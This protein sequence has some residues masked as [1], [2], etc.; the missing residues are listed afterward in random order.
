M[1]KFWIQFVIRE[2]I[3]VVEAFVAG[4]KLNAAQ[5]TAAEKLIADA[6]EFLATL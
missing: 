4:S 3:S 5:K 6:G 2:A 1:G